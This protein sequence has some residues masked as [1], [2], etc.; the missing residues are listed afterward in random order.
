MYVSSANC[1]D[2]TYYKV[3]NNLQQMKLELLYFF[4]LI[5]KL[6]SLKTC[7]IL[8]Y[9][10]NV[11]QGRHIYAFIA[12]FSKTTLNSKITK[13]LFYQAHTYLS[14]TFKNCSSNLKK[15]ANSRPLASNFKKFSRS[16]EQFFLTVG[17]NNFG[18]KIPFPI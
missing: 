3:Q 17:Q 1:I 9:N 16:L 18:N 14:E 10:Y 4:E 6:I 5:A 2:H 15:F 8:L 13:N 12:I 11:L 7:F